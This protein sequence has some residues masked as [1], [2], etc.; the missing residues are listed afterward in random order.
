VHDVPQTRMILVEDHT[1]LREILARSLAAEPGFEIVGQCSSVDDAVELV[2]RTFVD[3]VLL[4]INLGTEQGGSFI[5]RSRAEGFRGKVL[6]LTAG[7]SNREAAWLLNRGCAGIVLKHEPSAALID[8]IRK[9]MNPNRSDGATTQASVQSR[10]GLPDTSRKILTPRE[11]Q[12]LRAV[13]EGLANKEIAARLGLSENT[14]KSFLQQLFG[15]TG[16]RT[17]AQLVGAAIESYWDQ[18]GEPGPRTNPSEYC[19]RD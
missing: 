16:V 11:R 18:V 3:L 17:R 19:Q 10:P 9:L 4:D 1:L 5:T 7:V 12:V 2:G 14:V 6:V 15:K 13:C 8:R